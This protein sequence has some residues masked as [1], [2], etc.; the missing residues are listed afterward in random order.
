LKRFY[1]CFIITVFF[2]KRLICS[3]HPMITTL[4]YSTAEIIG[5]IAPRKAAGPGIVDKRLDDGV[6]VISMAAGKV[7][8][9]VLSGSLSEGDAVNVTQR[10]NELVLQKTG[11]QVQSG[12]PAPQD[13]V[14]VMP[15]RTP[16]LFGPLSTPS[17]TSSRNE[18]LTNQRWISSRGYSPQSRKHPRHSTKTRKSRKPTQVHSLIHAF[19]RH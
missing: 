3:K 13:A 16:S 14:D 15:R 7:T 1:R 10:G 11:S 18:Y 8:V 2:A 9:K 4:P 5:A 17:S 19:R 6:Y 12:A